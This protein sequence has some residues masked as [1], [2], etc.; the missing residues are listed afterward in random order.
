MYVMLEVLGLMGLEA[1]DTMRIDD[2]MCLLVA[3]A[4]AGVAGFIGVDRPARWR[5]VYQGRVVLE[6]LRLV[7]LFASAFVAVY[8]AG[9]FVERQRQDGINYASWWTVLIAGAI[10]TVLAVHTA[11][12]T[13]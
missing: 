3:A 1:A 10:A 9:L 11:R 8:N 4:A 12:R 7:A 2:A 6:R 13:T 5:A